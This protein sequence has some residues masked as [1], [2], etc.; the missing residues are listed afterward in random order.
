MKNLNRMLL[1]R[2]TK[3]VSLDSAKQSWMQFRIDAGHTGQAT[4]LLTPPDG[5]AKF[6]K[7]AKL[8][9]G[10]SLAAADSSG[11]FNTCTWSTPLCRKGCLTFAGRGMQGTVQTARML[12]TDFLAEDPD[13]FVTLLHYEV[14]K[15]IGRWGDSARIRFNV[16]SDLEWDV[17]APF[18]FTKDHTFYDYTK[19]MD[20]AVAALDNP[21]YRVVFSAS[22]RTTNNDIIALLNMGVIVNIVFSEGV[23]DTHLGRPVKDIDGD[24]DCWN[25]ERGQLIGVKAKGLMRDTE[26]FVPFV[27]IGSKAPVILHRLAKVS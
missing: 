8:H 1:K 13:S 20:R 18:L 6:N 21:R 14:E 19:G 22:E 7:S 4:P 2:G 23:P 3:L 26:T 10:V 12:K 11:T 17:F 15:A 5:N 9:Y 16:F 27:R 24:D 25:H